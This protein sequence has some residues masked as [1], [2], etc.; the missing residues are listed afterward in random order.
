[1]RIPLIKI[2]AILALFLTGLSALTLTDN[3][4]GHNF[5]N[6]FQAFTDADP[7]GG[8]VQYHNYQIAVSNKN[9]GTVANYQNASYMGVDAVNVMTSG[10]PSVRITSNKSYNHGL[11]MADIAH[12]PGGTCGVWP[13]FWL[14]GPDWPS[15]GEI[16]IL[17]GANAQLSNQMT[18][19]TGD[20]C[21]IGTTGYLG[22]A[23]TL[24]CNTRAPDQPE[25]AGCGIVSQD[26]KSYGAGFNQIGGGVYAM[27]WNSSAIAI[28]FWPR[29]SIP[30]DISSG[31]PDPST[32]PAP[33]SLFTGSCDI[34]KN[35]KNLQIVF[36]TTFCGQWAGKHWAN[37]TCASK[38]ST[39]EE[40]VGQNPKAF[41]DAYW[42]VNYVKV[43]D[44]K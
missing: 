10:R 27:H 44:E 26:N 6:N 7:T 38:A 40:Y 13:A 2:V 9:V 23:V 24:N 15:N 19:H 34:D 3:Y 29:S 22:K 30:S 1:M 33:M 31:N 16:D 36:D 18:L 25:N 28:W 8:F 20:D 37:S 5:F 17:E 32:W 12:M 21:L 42:L 11:F 39:C 14:V 41:A 35:F 4:S 43:F